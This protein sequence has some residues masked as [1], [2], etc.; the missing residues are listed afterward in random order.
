MLG[1]SIAPFL[2]KLEQRLDLFF[3]PKRFTLLVSPSDDGTEVQSSEEGDQS[4][5]SR[6]RLQ[7]ARQR[8]TTNARNWR[9][10]PSPDIPIHKWQSLDWFTRQTTSTSKTFTPLDWK[11]HKEWVIYWVRHRTRKLIMGHLEAL[12]IHL[13]IQA[14]N[15]ENDS[16]Y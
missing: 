1:E 15:G 13:P 8:T 5:A 6:T 9:K 10:R 16:Q 7:L 11:P 4:I 3:D 14:M 12:L 2:P